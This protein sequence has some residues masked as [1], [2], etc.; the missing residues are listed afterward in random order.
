L[1]TQTPR[2]LL[3]ELAPQ[4]TVGLTL[5][6]ILVVFVIGLVVLV[7]LVVLVVGLTLIVV[8]VVLTTG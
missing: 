4:V 3:Y 1:Q 2:P 6:V 8:L 5:T 7:A